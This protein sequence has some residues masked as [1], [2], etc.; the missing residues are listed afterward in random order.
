MEMKAEEPFTVATGVDDN[1]VLPF[2]VMI[3]SAK[4]NAVAKFHVKIGFD[5][6]ALSTR[7]Q[8]LLTRA[9]R[10]IDVSFE[11]VNLS[12]S[13]EM[14]SSY[15]I[16]ATAYSRLLL[17]DQFTGLLLWLDCDLICLPG[18][19]TIFKDDEN[20]PNGMVMSVVRDPLVSAK[21]TVFLRESSNE[22]VRIMGSDYFNSGVALI[23]CDVWKSR[24]YPQ[25]WPTIL[26]EYSTRG[27]EYAD[28]CV[29]N[30]LCQ[31]QVK[32][33][34]WRY[35]AHARSKKHNRKKIPYILHF[36]GGL[37]PWSYSIFDSRILKGDLF[38][39]DVH[40]YLRYQSKLIKSIRVEDPA[41]GSILIDEKKRIRIP[42]RFSRIDFDR[43]FL[44]R[45]R[46]QFKSP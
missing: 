46:D 23:D 17:A 39:G 4:V 29:L 32:Y 1:Y 18:W 43:D 28:Q 5:P 41:L 8:E 21:G 26:L 38:Y 27:F 22:S 7:N 24:N 12:L 10:L 16:T 6:Q 20:L 3:Y 42:F 36:A 9:L 33:L 31:H 19:E 2:L 34:P 44:A 35:N 37:K 11:M 30:F 15:H 45:M 25:I 13:K 40:K 14:E